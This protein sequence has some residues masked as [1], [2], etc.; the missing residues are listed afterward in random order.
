MTSATPTAAFQAMGP[1]H[2]AAL[3]RLVL[4]AGGDL[5]TRQYD[6]TTI[7]ALYRPHGLSVGVTNANRL[8][9]WAEIARRLGVTEAGSF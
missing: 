6:G 8:Q 9:G 5:L 1:S 7:A 2:L 4:A 3:A